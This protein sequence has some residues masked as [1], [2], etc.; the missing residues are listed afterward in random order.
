MDIKERES[1]LNIL[2]EFVNLDLNALPFSEKAAWG[3]RFFFAYIGLFL[4][5]DAMRDPTHKKEFDGLPKIQKVLSVHI[6]KIMNAK[7]GDWFFMPPL[8]RKFVVGDFF[9]IKY[10]TPDDRFG[11]VRKSPDTSVVIAEFNELLDGLPRT[12]LRTCPECVR[13]YASLSKRKK[14]YCS[15]KCAYRFLSRKRRNELK[16]HPRK[17]KRFLK[18]QRETMHKVYERKRKQEFGPNV[19]VRRNGRKED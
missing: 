15:S 14:E 8:E 2:L 6:Q 13:I 3:A 9:N 5:Q 16:K 12:A 11:D 1:R 4:D 19:K 10:S 18:K 17:Y 7:T